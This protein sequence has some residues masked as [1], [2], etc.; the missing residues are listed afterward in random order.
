[1]EL[2]YAGHPA[3]CGVHPDY[4]FRI[5]H[6]SIIPCPYPD[7][8]NGVREGR[9]EI[10]CGDVVLR[11]FEA[12][13]QW[14]WLVSLKATAP[15]TVPTTRAQQSAQVLRDLLM[16]TTPQ[17]MADDLLTVDK[18]RAVSLALAL[19][20]RLHAN[21]QLEVRDLSL[22]EPRREVFILCT[23]R[24]DQGVVLEQRP[25]YSRRENEETRHLYYRLGGGRS[26]RSLTSLQ[27]TD[28]GFVDRDRRNP[29]P[30]YTQRG[31]SC[32]SV[33]G[34]QYHTVLCDADWYS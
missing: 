14:S 26:A 12:A 23:P 16:D 28:P 7:C 22:Q 10:D 32:P 25:R 15:V 3:K 34:V 9:E 33:D 4:R 24:G 21:G 31:C 8:H 13:G 27:A 20:E 2:E 5:R 6:G 11:R 29:P 30:Y 1:M 19:V 17:A 18:D